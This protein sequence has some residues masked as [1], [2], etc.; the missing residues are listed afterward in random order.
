LRVGGRLGAIVGTA[1]VMCAQIVTRISEHCYETLR[2]FE[3]EVKTLRNAWQPS[4][5]QF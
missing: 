2:L 5:F 3:T 4:S 1:P